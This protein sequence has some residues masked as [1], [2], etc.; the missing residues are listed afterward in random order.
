M[1]KILI[2]GANSYIGTSFENYMKQY[3]DYQIDT[4]DMLDP[5]WKEYDFSS[6]D[7]V[8]HV[9]GIAHQKETKKNRD[10]YYKV[11]RDLAIKVA[12]IAKNEG[13]NHFIFMSSMSVYGLKTGHI[14]KETVE[15]PVSAYGDS[16]L[17]AENT[18]LKLKSPIFKVT[19]MRPPMIYGK[20][21]IGNYQRLKKFAL[22]S[23]VFPSF[24]NKRSM[25]FIYNFTEFIKQV[26]DTGHE[27][28]LLPQDAEYVSTSKMV[29][30]IAQYNNKYI[31]FTK[32]FNPIIKYC[33]L[34]IIKKIFGS[35]TYEKTDI[36]SK[37]NFT[38]SIKISENYK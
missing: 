27:G 24:T 20:N 9:A 29:E 31:W 8:F 1:K 5:K 30:L 18:I 7:T 26:V 4:L 3:S 12:N 32:I 36:V 28:I 34:G 35:L 33:S 16:K 15:S 14:T 21:C 23:P 25:L 13:V 2:T 10:L 11:N 6:Y 17:Q 19:I 37:Y 22:K 38:E